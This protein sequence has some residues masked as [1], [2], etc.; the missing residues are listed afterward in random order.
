MWKTI[1]K[2]RLLQP[3][4]PN[5][6]SV[7][8]G[9]TV[10]PR[11]SRTN[12]GHGWPHYGV[13]VTRRLKTLGF[14]DWVRSYYSVSLPYF[15]FQKNIPLQGSFL[16]YFAEHRLAVT[17]TRDFC[18]CKAPQKKRVDKTA[19]MFCEDMGNITNGPTR[20]RNNNWGFWPL[21]HWLAYWFLG[22][23]EKHHRYWLFRSNRKCNFPGFT[24]S[25]PSQFAAKQCKTIYCS[26][27]NYEMCP[28]YIVHLWWYL[29]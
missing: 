24:R 21:K 2:T 4:Q 16:K 19:D 1:L 29:I 27:I 25:S 5:G 10:F 6:I 22:M 9:K 17:W 20:S 13:V 26:S 3:F 18:V 11:T 14:A 15:D 28:L 7:H 12:L 23:G 8:V